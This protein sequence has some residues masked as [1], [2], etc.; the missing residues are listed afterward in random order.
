MKAHYVALVMSG[1][2][3]H[4]AL[5]QKI[6]LVKDFTSGIV[7]LITNAVCDLIHKPGQPNESA[8]IKPLPI[9]VYITVCEIRHNPRLVKSF[10]P[11]RLGRG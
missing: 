9:Q 7:K 1:R 5:R 10:T 3:C 4:D 2:L 6:C 8:F 11:T